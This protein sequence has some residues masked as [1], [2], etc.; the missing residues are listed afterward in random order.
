MASA[1]TR[2][3]E[4]I[5]EQKH[6]RNLTVKIIAKFIM[7]DIRSVFNGRILISYFEES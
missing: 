4:A 3:A 7:R 2:W 1:F 6:L 5:N